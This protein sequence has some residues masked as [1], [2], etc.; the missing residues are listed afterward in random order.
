MSLLKSLIVALIVFLCVF[1]IFITRHY[2]IYCSYAKRMDNYLVKEELKEQYTLLCESAFKDYSHHSIMKYSLDTLYY[3]FAKVD[4][5][6]QEST[7]LTAYI[8]NVNYYSMKLELKILKSIHL[9]F[10]MIVLYFL[11]VV[12]PKKLIDFIL[13]IINKLLF[14]FF[15]ILIGEAVLNLYM[16]LQVDLIW[17]IKFIY[18]Y[19]PLNIIREWLFSIF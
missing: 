16:D 4:F 15:L 13:F 8:A 9:V 2:Y 17:L 10:Y 7:R 14:V 3:I 1:Y 11:I 12:L 18:G 6:E 5:S 19:L